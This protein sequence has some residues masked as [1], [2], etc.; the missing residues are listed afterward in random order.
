MLLNR[1]LETYLAQP[2]QNLEIIVVDDWSTDG[3]EGVCAAYAQM[4]DLKYIRPGYKHPGV[5]RDGASIINIGI[6]AARGDLIAITHPEIMVGRHTIG[7]AVKM[8]GSKKAIFAK[9]YWL[10]HGQQQDID[11]VNWKANTQNVANMKGFYEQEPPMPGY[12]DYTHRH[13]EEVQ[14]WGSQQWTAML[15]EDWHW[16]GGL[17]EFSEWGSVDMDFLSRRRVL[18]IEDVTLTGP[19]TMCVH[20]NHDSGPGMFERNMERA[21]SVLR[22]YK[23]P[24]DAIRSLW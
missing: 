11:S 15:R 16:I 14:V 24:E 18:G 20:Q 6:R 8:A 22:E 4:L 13:M 1:S 5:K 12:P 17:T 21:K 7:D 23:S 3:T 9:C 10:T 2:Y 19:Q